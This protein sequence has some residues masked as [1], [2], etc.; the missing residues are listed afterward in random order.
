MKAKLYLDEIYDALILQPFYALCRVMAGFD[1]KVVDGL[2]NGAGASLETSGHVLKL[3]HSGFVRNYALLYLVG[4]A[5]IV[6]YLV[7]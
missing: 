1:L 3:F 2:V 7:L 4:A 6:W 5:A